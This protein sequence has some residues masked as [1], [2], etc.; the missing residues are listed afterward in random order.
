M[1]LR[2]IEGWE[3]HSPSRQRPWALQFEAGKVTS[4]RLFVYGARML[5]MW[6]PQRRTI[7]NSSMPNSFIGY[8]C[9]TAEVR[10]TSH[11]RGGKEKRSQQEGE[12]RTPL[13][14]N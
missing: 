7:S 6:S 10:L 3:R 9:N 2:P 13:M 14:S 12:A 11:G 4:M 8:L 1:K 5:V